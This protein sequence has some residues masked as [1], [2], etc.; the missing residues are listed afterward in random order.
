MFKRNI[1]STAYF[2]KEETRLT[3][4]GCVILYKQNIRIEY[5]HGMKDYDLN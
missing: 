4:R 1:I 3:K 5:Q 2:V